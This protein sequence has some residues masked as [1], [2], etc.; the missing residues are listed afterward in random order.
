MAR[1]R[2]APVGG[3]SVS[4]SR[5]RQNG[6]GGGGTRT[7]PAC[8]IPRVWP[9]RVGLG[10]GGGDPADAAAR[11]S[12]G[13]SHPFAP[14]WRPSSAVLPPGSGRPRPSRRPEPGGSTAGL[15]GYRTP[16]D[17]ACAGAVSAPTPRTGCAPV[18]VPGR[19][20]QPAP[21]LPM[22][23]RGPESPVMVANSRARAASMFKRTSPSCTA[24]TLLTGR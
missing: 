9:R 2:L 4:G 21:M 17:E 23:G 8:R 10:F 12:G 11:L 14:W 19:P 15:D 16:L 13:L 22:P 24:A 3:S 18:A 5:P 6:G 20:R 1:H 7:A